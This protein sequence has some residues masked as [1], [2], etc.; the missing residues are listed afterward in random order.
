MVSQTTARVEGEQRSGSVFRARFTIRVPAPGQLQA[1]LEA[2]EH[3]L[4]HQSWPNPQELPKD[5]KFQPVPSL[6]QTFEISVEGGRVQSLNLPASLPLSQEN[7]LKGLIGALQVD[8]STH[9]H[10]RSHQYSYDKQAQKG[11]F[12][13]METDVT[14]DCETL[15]TVSPVASEWRRELPEFATAEDPIEITK[16]KNYGHC[17]HRVAYHFGVPEGSEWTGTAHRTLEEQFIRRTSVS[18]IFAGKQGPIYK[19]ETTNVAQV[20]PHLYGKQKAQVLSYVKFILKS[21]EQDNEA[22]WPT[23]QG[24]RKV[25]N[26]LYS[27]TNKQV[28]ISDDSSSSSSE[29]QEFIQVED[30]QNRVRRSANVANIDK[31]LARG[32][33]EDDSSSSS[34]SSES[35]QDFVNDDLP[36]IN[37]PAYAA[38]YMSPQAHADKKQ[39]AMNAQKL[40]QD[41]AQQLQNPNNMP[42]AD[43]LS[44]FNILVRIL[45][46][47]SYNQLTQ[48]SRTIEIAK[49][50]NNNLKNDMWMIYRDAVVQA[51][52]LPAFQQIEKWIQDKKIQEEE[53]AQVV[54]SLPSAL[55]YPTKEVMIQFFNLAMKDEVRQQMYLNTT[56]LIAAAKLINMGQVNNDSAHNY[57]PTHMYGRLSRKND[58]FVYQQVLPRLSQELSQAI[59]QEDSNKAQVYIKAIGILGHPSILPVFAP[60]LEGKIQVSTYLRRQMV[61]NLQYLAYQRNKLVRSVLYTI[62][63]NTA[64]HQQVR[65]AA[66]NNIW[67]TNPTSTMAMVMA[68]M[69]YND[70][71]MNVRSALKSSIV[72]AAQLKNPRF[73]D[74]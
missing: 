57:Y 31:P 45:A 6:E 32:S 59:Q 15:Y 1:R 67:M 47:M 72:S 48:T 70:P 41:M 35:R 61:N 40:V 16:S 20:H 55:R 53:A 56:A 27:M 54:A 60:Y 51:G 18:R 8:L 3:A 46:S 7:L 14:G 65:V 10:V 52:T 68:Q 38:L 4:V 25:N 36:N 21:Y 11:L 9:R 39:N 24:G 22:A 49:S 29:S 23:L 30:A 28:T 26:L 71:S 19:S 12:S 43:F 44:K 62:L 66:I 42:K 2:P 13:K 37:E 34:S 58:P 5:L 63:R 69:S 73:M 17:H 64:E 74:M 33:T 50:S